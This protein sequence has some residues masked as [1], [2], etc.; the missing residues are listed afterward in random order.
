MSSLFD[1]I[2]H[3]I[4][5][6]K[7]L[8]TAWFTGD[9]HTKIHVHSPFNGIVH[10]IFTWKPLGTVWTSGHLLRECPKIHVHC[11]I[12]LSDIVH[13]IFTWKPRGAN[14]K[15]GIDWEECLN[16]LVLSLLWHCSPDLHLKTP[17]DCLVQRRSLKR[18]S[19]DSRAKY[20]HDLNKK[21]YTEASIKNCFITWCNNLF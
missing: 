3:Q 1:D 19:K 12:P 5:T 6:W 4:F 21:H 15:I 10:Q 13:Q 11:S 2:V 18:M 8:G 17:R 16:I 20:A 9:I 14:W 7:P